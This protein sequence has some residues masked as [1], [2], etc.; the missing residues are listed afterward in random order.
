[1]DKALSNNLK[2][3]NTNIKSKKPMKKKTKQN[4]DEK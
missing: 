4:I 3:E 2:E 1:L